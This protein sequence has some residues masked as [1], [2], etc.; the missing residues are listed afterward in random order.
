M[1]DRLFESEDIDDLASW[2]PETPP[3]E[4]LKAAV[5]VQTSR[6]VRRRARL[7]RMRRLMTI[8]TAYAAGIATAV[9][10]WRHVEPVRVVQVAQAP[11][12]PAA[13]HENR[14]SQRRA[15]K[16]RE[17]SDERPGQFDERQLASLSPAELRR[18]VPDAPREQQ[19]RLLEMAGDRYLYGR[20]DVASALDCYRQVLELTPPEARREAQPNDSWL[21]AEL[22]MAPSE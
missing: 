19:I 10:A 5:L 3:A 2:W 14:S 22:K 15:N 11:A 1:S 7:R 4:Q 9:V 8:A 16:G 21:L 13:W 17:V 12:P 18:L 20:A 6:V